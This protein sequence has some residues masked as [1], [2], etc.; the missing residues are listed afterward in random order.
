MLLV[1]RKM[2]LL[3]ILVGSRIGTILPSF[4]MLVMDFNWMEKLKISVRA[5]IATGTHI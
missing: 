1:Y 2:D 5:Q 3:V 4:L